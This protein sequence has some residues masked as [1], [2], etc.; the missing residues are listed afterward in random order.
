[1]HTTSTSAPMHV[2][3]QGHGLQIHSPHYQLSYHHERPYARLSDSAGRLYSELFLAPSL[4]TTAGLD[5]TA[6]LRPPEIEHDG[7]TVTVRFSLEGGIWQHKTLV[8]RCDPGGID[9]FVEVSGSAWLTDVHLFGGY[10]SGHQR[11]GS[12]FFSSGAGFTHAFNPEPY[13]REQRLV[14]AGQSSAID[15]M[16]TS[17]PGKGHWFFTP[18]P[19][20]YAFSQQHPA[21]QLALGADQGGSPDEDGAEGQ[22][23]S[24][25]WLGASI[26]APVEELNFTAFHY[27]ALEGAFSFRLSYEGQTEVDGH[28][29]SPTLRLTFSDDP[30]EA[31]A[32]NS[33]RHAEL[34]I[35][36]H[37]PQPQPEWWSTPI[38]CGW[39]AQCHLA[40]EHGGRAPDHCTQQNYDAF[41]DTLDAHDLQPGILVLDDKWCASYGTSEVDR[42]K[43][44]DLEGWIARAHRRGQRV[45]LWWKAWDAEGLPDDACILDDLGERVTADPTSPSYEAILRGAV[46]RMLLEYGADGFKV[47]FSARTPS[48]PGLRRAG[49]AWGLHLLH[50]LLWILHDEAKRCKSDALVMT[51]TPHP[52]FGN[53]TD[54][55]RLNDV[56]TG[57]D[58]NEQMTHRAR[59]TR[60]ALPRHLIDTDNWPMPSLTAWRAYTRL[61]PELGIPSLYFVTHT[62][63]DGQAFTAADYDLVRDTWQRYAQAKRKP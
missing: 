54:M 7:Q 15:V 61:Q 9:T 29:R 48:G 10:Y 5:R 56:N 62:D 45:L 13:A 6:R 43:W 28:F 18:A 14:P 2:E 58:V 57:A 50:R 17:L 59:V 34:H 31:I 4:H 49:S 23:L 60:A 55:I 12:G 39:G 25:R 22:P 46:R 24:S 1:M 37:A 27:D 32:Q 52:V 8:L 16:G 35:T 20:V 63:G 40:R 3:H 19:L 42:H 53:V 21:G 47:D 41:L 36:A 26:V 11:W 30:Y 44:P 33:A 51:H 38:Q